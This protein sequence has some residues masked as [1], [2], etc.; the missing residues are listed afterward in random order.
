MS[1]ADGFNHQIPVEVRFHDLDAFGHVNNARFLNYLEQARL[2]YAK[3]VCSWDGQLQSLGLI[4]ANVTIDFKRPLH[5]GDSVM[6]HSRVSRL[7]NKSFDLDYLFI[8]T[9]SEDEAAVAATART[10]LV[11][12]DYTLNQTVP[13]FP[14]WRAGILAHEPDLQG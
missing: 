6:L 5:L 2:S 4:V 10:T 14:E 11:T 12:Y 7:G 1:L 3:E 9:P 8:V 13:I